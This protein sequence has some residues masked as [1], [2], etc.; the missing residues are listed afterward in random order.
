MTNEEKIKKAKGVVCKDC[1]WNG[2]S[3][4]ACPS[5]QETIEAIELGFTEGRKEGYELG[6]N[7]KFENTYMKAEEFDKY[8]ELAKENEQLKEKV[9]SLEERLKLEEN[10]ANVWQ[11]LS[12][13]DV[14][15]LEYFI[16]LFQEAN[17]RKRYWKK[18]YHSLAMVH[19][20]C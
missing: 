20:K 9:R 10:T 15:L 11:D 1:C 14:H 4:N 2:C 19:Y 7:E 8:L 6:C 12:L 18:L 13:S 3:N 17:K 16:K 5:L